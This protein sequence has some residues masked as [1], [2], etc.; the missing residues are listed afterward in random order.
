MKV[1]ILYEQSFEGMKQTDMMNCKQYIINGKQFE[2]F[3]MISPTTTI[4]GSSR[5]DTNAHLVLIQKSRTLFLNTVIPIN[6]TIWD[7]IMITSQLYT[8]NC[9]MLLCFIEFT[10]F[11]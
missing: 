9:V 8:K 5:F 3:V 2:S 11:S 6:V 7:F 10:I 1:H 4:N